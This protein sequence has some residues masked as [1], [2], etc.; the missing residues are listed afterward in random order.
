ML[1]FNID[2]LYETPFKTTF[3]VNRN[4]LKINT[5]TENWGLFNVNEVTPESIIS[6]KT[7]VKLSNQ[8]NIC[9]NSPQLNTVKHSNK[10]IPICLWK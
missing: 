7:N 6:D 1:T 9:K 2:L 10:G 3:K 4:N 8:E 5:D